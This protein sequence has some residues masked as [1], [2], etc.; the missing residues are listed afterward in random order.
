[1]F[2]NLNF[3]KFLG[4]VLLLIPNRQIKKIAN[5]VLLITKLLNIYSHFA[6][7]DP[8][9]RFAPTLVFFLMLV[10]RM[11]VD[12]QFDKSLATEKVE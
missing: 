4:L 1:M 12:W 8:F 9:E 5:I 6:I 7:N 3:E 2:V 10:C 11:V